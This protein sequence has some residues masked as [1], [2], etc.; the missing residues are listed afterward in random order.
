MKKLLNYFHRKMKKFYFNESGTYFAITALMCTVL[1]SYVA[2]VVDGTGLL[3]DKVRFIQGL[4]EAGLFVTAENNETRQNK[5]HLKNGQTIKERNLDMIRQV[6][7]SYYQPENLYIENEGFEN[8]CSRNGIDL[9]CWINGYFKRPS[10]LFGRTV[11][12]SFKEK[13]TISS[14]NLFFKKKIFNNAPIDIMFVMDY[15]GSMKDSFKK[16]RKKKIDALREIIREISDDLLQKKDHNY[17]RIGITLFAGGVQL[18]DSKYSHL[19][20]YPFFYT[21]GTTICKVSDKNKNNVNSRSESIQNCEV[22]QS[23]K[24]NYYRSLKMIE[25]FDGSPLNK[26]FPKANIPMT[27]EKSK[28]CLEHHKRI[29]TSQWCDVSNFNDCF[30][31]IKKEPAGWTYSTTGLYVGANL[32]MRKNPKTENLKTNTKRFLVILSDG[33][34]NSDFEVN[35]FIIPANVKKDDLGFED[36][37]KLNDQ[38][39][40]NLGACNQIRKRIDSLQSSSYKHYETKISF[41]AI[42]YDPRRSDD[43]RTRKDAEAWQ[44]CVGESNYYVADNIESLKEAILNAVRSN[45]EVGQEQP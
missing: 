33:I 14:D 6:A 12:T 13:E 27:A 15:S 30:K 17:N 19:C 16:T 45:D 38:G 34:D 7:R 18:S 1:L 40:Q 5:T 10:W 29:N 25:D 26:R 23:P 2:F 9:T 37:Y 36:L 31:V 43:I 21:S 11:F 32:L 39:K 8:G 28:E 41:I 42:D 3:A 20:T 35:K 24:I 22:I 44:Q 4:T